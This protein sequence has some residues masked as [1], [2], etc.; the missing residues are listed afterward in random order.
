MV[1]T[2]ACIPAFLDPALVPKEL[3]ES[4]TRTQAIDGLSTSNLFD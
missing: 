2:T 1:F 4:S 3:H